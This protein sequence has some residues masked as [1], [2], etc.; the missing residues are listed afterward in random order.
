[1]MIRLAIFVALSSTL[2]ALEW[3]AADGT[4]REFEFDGKV[5]RTS[6]FIDAAGQALPVASDEFHLRTMDDREWT[7]DDFRSVGEPEKTA[8]GLV[9]RYVWPEGMALSENAPSKVTVTFESGSYLRKWIELEFPKAATIDRLE[10]ERFTASGTGTRGGRGEP[11]FLGDH[12]FFG[13]EYPAGHT[14]Y[15]DGNTPKPDSHR[16]ELVGNYSF[17]DLEG[18]DQEAKPRPGL[19]RLFHFPGFA[20]K[21]GERWVI[22]SKS[23]VVGVAKAGESMEQGFARYLESVAKPERSFTHYNNWFD[24][25]GKSLKGDNFIDIHRQF[26]AALKDYDIKIDAMVPDN[27]WQNN[28]SVWEPA[29]GHFPK[30]FDDLK[31]LSDSLRKEGTSLGLWLALDGTTTN[32][33]WGE[34]EGYQKAKANKYFGQFFPHYS[35]SADGYREQLEK[36]LRKLAGEAGVTYF[37]HDFNHLSDA[38]E[39]CNHPATDRHGHEANVDAMISLLAA[40]REANPAVY[41]NLT[42]WVWFSPWWLM[43]GDAL[44]MLAGDDGFNGNWPELSTRAMATTDRDAYV[45]RMWGDAADRPL[46]PV[47]RLMTHGIIRNPRGQM[48]GPEDTLRDWADHV[49]MYYGRGIQMKEWYLTPSAMSA[50][51]W[52]SLATIHRWSERNFKALANNVWI[53]GRPD[54]GHV[55]GYAGWDGERG[56]LVA[57]NPG[58]SP[59]VLR[60]PFDS[61]AGFAGEVGKDYLGRVVYPYHATWQAKFTAGR[62]MEIEIPGYETLA[63]EF[64]PGTPAAKRAEMPVVAVSV[65][66]DGPVAAAKVEQLP[67]FAGR[68]ELLVIGYPELPEVRI[69]GGI[70]TPLRTS[71]AALNHYAG[72]ARAGMPSD[73]V[74]PWQMASF[75]LKS[76]AGK[77]VAVEMRAG[78]AGTR[79]EA[80]LLAE[81]KA[82]DEGFNSRDLPWAV[83]ANARRQTTCLIAEREL[84]AAPVSRRA[85]T[86][87]ELRGIRKAWLTVEHFGI[88]AGYGAKTL[89]LNGAKLAELPTGPDEWQTARIEVPASLIA[90][91]KPENTV[92]LRCDSAED[93]FKFRGL[94][95]RVELSDGGQVR[96]GAQDSPQTSS[97]DWAHFE[98][99]SFLSEKVSKPVM[100][101]F[102]GD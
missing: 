31:A 37:K 49:M 71:K 13:L 20:K 48:E 79:A 98:G 76:K 81:T 55:Y 75:D 17:V 60:V 34:S 51:Q 97:K 38:G 43:H 6:G 88:N 67:D 95:L 57:R 11:V 102:R 63:F 4:R 100:L 44:W 84:R 72:Y 41:Q 22:R 94:E 47:S 8:A 58:P 89:F 39:G 65:K 80:W 30:G 7:V 87:S 3:R 45:W 28:A 52:K 70:A 85:L 15:G 10:V 86:D 69:D 83:S 54:E 26:R 77:A 16:Y 61:A 9:L 40:T 2:S 5:W 66:A 59:Q 96:S 42:N 93:K 82:T 32:I 46:V 56:V 101:R 19:I 24:A 23:A 27:G 99:E 14:R 53:G 12:W 50:E 36:Q 33:G 35:L 62:A 25:S 74:R 64:K 73:R 78:E 92:E 21:D 29:A 18:R 1:M 68:G 90:K 91:L